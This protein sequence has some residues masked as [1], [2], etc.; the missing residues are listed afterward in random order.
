MEEPCLEFRV[1]GYGPLRRRGG[2]MGEVPRKVS[3]HSF[4]DLQAR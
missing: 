2:S 3:F 1:D 4:K